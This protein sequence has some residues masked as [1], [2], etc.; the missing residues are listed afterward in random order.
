MGSGPLAMISVSDGVRI[1]QG[2]LHGGV[3]LNDFEDRMAEY[4]W[5]I[6]KL[7]SEPAQKLAYLI[8]SMLSSDSNEDIDENALREELEKAIRPFAGSAKR[9]PQTGVVVLYF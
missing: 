6:H 1:V 3:S 2:F 9:F 4:S 7:G 8:Q 5:N